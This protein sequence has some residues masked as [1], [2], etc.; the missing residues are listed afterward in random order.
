MGGKLDKDVIKAEINHFSK[1]AVLEVS[2]TY[3]DVPSSHWASYVIKE[4]A[5]KQIVEGT[6]ATTFEPER[7]VTRAEFT[8]LLV[9]ALKLLGLRS[10]NRVTKRL[11]CVVE[12]STSG[13]PFFMPSIAC[14]IEVVTCQ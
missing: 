5:A 7:S 10:Y 1:Y 8:T 11:I 12:V 13:Q 6:S 3:S 14:E 4:L 2:K 9:R